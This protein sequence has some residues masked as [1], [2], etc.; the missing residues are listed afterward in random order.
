M[1]MHWVRPVS[2]ALRTYCLWKDLE[3]FGLLGALLRA[4]SGLYLEAFG[5]LFGP[6]WKR[7]GV[8]GVRLGGTIWAAPRAVWSPS[9]TALGRS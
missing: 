1:C 4:S 6:S 2:N 8:S 9:G 5:S 7:L 3:Q